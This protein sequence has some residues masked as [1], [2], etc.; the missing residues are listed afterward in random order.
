MREKLRR[1][2]RLEQ[3]MTE[4][5]DREFWSPP[6][7]D[8]LAAARQ[9]I[10]STAR[11]YIQAIL[12]DVHHNAPEQWSPLTKEFYARIDAYLDNPSTRLM[13]TDEEIATLTGARK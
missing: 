5:F 4:T 2:E 1:V 3:Q 11:R 7:R 8:W 6:D 12:E 10:N 13:F 9:L